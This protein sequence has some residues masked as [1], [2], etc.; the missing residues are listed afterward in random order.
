MRGLMVV[1]VLLLA[2]ASQPAA[3]APG[4][5]T[6]EGIGTERGSTSRG[7]HV[8][9]GLAVRVGRRFEIGP[10]ARFY[11]LEASSG[12]DPSL[13]YWIGGRFGVRF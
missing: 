13:A 8:G 7:F 4:T 10:E 9:A 2:A 5:T 6:F 3:A 11:F 1:D 12:S